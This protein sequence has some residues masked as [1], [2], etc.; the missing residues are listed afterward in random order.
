MS[1]L[2]RAVSPEQSLIVHSIGDVFLYAQYKKKCLTSSVCNKTED[3]RYAFPIA[4][5]AQMP[6]IQLNY[7]R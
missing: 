1:L 3:F 6:S 7:R 4:P 2:K 5:G